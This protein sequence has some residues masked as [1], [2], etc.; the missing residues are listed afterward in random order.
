MNELTWPIVLQAAAV[1]VILAEIF[2]PSGGLLGIIAA[3]LIGYSLYLVFT[4]VS[5]VAGILFV[6]NDIIL[7]PVLVMVGL[8]LIARSPAT[9][10][11]TLSAVGG[12]SSQSPEMADYLHMEGETLTD[13]RPSGIARINGKRVDVATRGEYIEKNTPVYVAAVTGNQIIVR[14]KSPRLNNIE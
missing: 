7:L 8:K 2:I 13:L 14:E 3:G 4:G 9:L 1:L 10:K 11:K 5:Q 6:V 12:V